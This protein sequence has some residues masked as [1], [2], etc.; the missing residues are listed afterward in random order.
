M[1]LPI[2]LIAVGTAYTIHVLN[3][4]FEE[5]AHT[6]DK[7]VAVEATL[8][9]VALPVFLAGAT[10]F[11]GFGSLIVSSIDALKMFGVLS[12][13]GILFALILSLTLTPALMVLLPLPKA[14]TIEKHGKS[15]LAE[16]LAG[17][18]RFVGNR[19]VPVLVV[20]LV[21]VAF[22]ALFTP[23]VSFETNTINSFKK[24]SEVRSS[25]DYLNENFTGITVMTV[26]VAVDEEGAILDPAVLRAMDGLQQRVD[27]L[28]VVK[29]KGSKGIVVGPESP[30]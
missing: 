16:L 1:I 25:S 12:A 2:I 28:R 17:L 11:I 5:L 22:F 23:R 10:T 13:L 27:A 18:G 4:Y 7:P 6:T 26:V 14:K 24:G 30:L 20:S 9:H 15:R 19:P 21:V 3:R 8:T 29:G